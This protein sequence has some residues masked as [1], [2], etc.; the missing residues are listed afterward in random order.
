MELI[1]KLKKHNITKYKDLI[2]E[3]RLKSN[4]RLWFEI[5]QIKASFPNEWRKLLNKAKKEHKE[6][7]YNIPIK[8]NIW[9]KTENINLRDIIDRIKT[10]CPIDNQLIY[11]LNKHKLEQNTIRG[12]PF[13][14]LL[15]T[16]KEAKLRN[17][18]F[19]I[20]HN[21]YPS[22]SHLHKWKLKDNPNCTLCKVKETTIHAIYECPIAR[23]AIKK[24]EKE[25]KTSYDIEINISK[26]DMLLGLDSNENVNQFVKDIN[27]L[28]AILII[29]KRKL[30]LQR[31]NKQELSENEIME[32]IGRQ[33]NLEKYLIFKETNGR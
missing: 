17:V 24:L 33:I 1:K 18:Q 3:D 31:E 2:K 21:I 5:Y 13:K 30:I 23:D 15:K 16:T 4:V 25:L 6:I 22:M 26:I 14:T 20:L 10:K 29:L 27:I 9:R 12:N 28:N 7:E 19:K 8:L 32:I 11:V